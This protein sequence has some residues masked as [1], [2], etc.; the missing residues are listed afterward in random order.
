MGSVH[1]Y[2][3]P[4]K[5]NS[6]MDGYWAYRKV[7]SISGQPEPVYLDSM[8]KIK[9]FNSAEGLSAPGEVPTNATVSADG[10]RILSDGMPGNWRGSLPEVPSAV[11]RM[12]TSLTALSGKDPAPVASGPPCTAQAVDAKIMEQFTSSSDG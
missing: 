3:D 11:W 4:N 2:T 6:H 7:S 5:E 8:Q 9:E 12:T 10:K 1:K